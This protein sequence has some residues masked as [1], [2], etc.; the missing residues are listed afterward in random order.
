LKD[1][2]NNSNYDIVVIGGGASGAGVCLDSS[3]R[4]LRTLVI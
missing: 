4:G 1:I 3:T 2:K